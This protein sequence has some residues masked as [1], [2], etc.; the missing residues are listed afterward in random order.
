MP[1]HF[2]RAVLNL[3]GVEAFP[4][5]AEFEGLLVRRGPWRAGF[6]F[7]FGQP[8]KLLRNLG[9]KGDWGEVVTRLTSRGREDFMTLLND[10]RAGRVE[11]DKQHLRTTDALAK[12]CSQMM[13]YGT[14]VGKMFF[15]GAPRLLRSG[16]SILPVRPGGDNRVAVEV[17]PKLVAAR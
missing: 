1:G 9:L 3:E 4:G 11:G 6:D 2:D 5:F 12:S 17:Y 10:Y 8:R 15:E 16:I 7:P 13:L 14:P